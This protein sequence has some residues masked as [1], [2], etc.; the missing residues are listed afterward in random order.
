MKRIAI[1]AVVI[2]VIVGGWS[3]AWLYFSGMIRTNVTALA[4]AD[5]QQSPRVVCDHL[6][7]GGFPFWFD[8]SCDGMTVTSG[9]VTARLASLQATILAYDPWHALIQATSPLT[10]QDAFT[11]SKKQLGWKDMDASARLTGW[12]I[13]RISVIADALTLDETVAGNVPLAKASHA[14]FHL[15]D[16][17]AQHDPKKGLAALAVYAKADNLSAPGLQINDG[18]STLDAQITGLSDDVRTYGDPDMLKRWQ[19]AGGQIKLVGL[20]GTD[21]PQDFAVT[22]KL[23]L[24]PQARPEG[25]LTIASKGLVERLGTVVPEQWRS[26]VLGNPGPDGSYHQ[27]LNLT[28]GLV[29]SGVI[30]LGTLPALM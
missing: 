11:G 19:A 4:Y 28:N 14:E 3:I 30:P 23:G 10:V 24:D 7:V 2:A 6:D 9:D 15:L 22:G 26:L 16:I 20:K 8:V 13:G 27:V 18:H 21:G 29:F 12:R 17:P 25:Q 1:L 5:G